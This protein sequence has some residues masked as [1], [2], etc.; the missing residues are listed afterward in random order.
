M[1]EVVSHAL[2]AADTLLI[3]STAGGWDFT[4]PEDPDQLAAELRRHGVLPGQRLHVVPTPRTPN[5]R[6][7][8]RGALAGHDRSPS[9][10]D[11]Q[12][13]SEQATA[14]AE[15][16]YQDGGRWDSLAP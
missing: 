2:G 16:R 13:A 10:E 1:H 11:F 12:A 5:P 15:A 9:W 8:L 4:V 14:E 7:P 3:M 6:R